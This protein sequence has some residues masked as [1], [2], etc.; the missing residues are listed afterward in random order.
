MRYSLTIAPRP[1]RPLGAFAGLTGLVR[2]GREVKVL[3]AGRD[4]RVGPAAGDHHVRVPERAID[5]RA[6]AGV[7]ELLPDPLEV[8]DAR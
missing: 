3:V 1:S 4:P 6:P 8:R 2:A 7:G 5:E